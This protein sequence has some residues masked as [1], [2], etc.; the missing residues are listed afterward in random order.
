MMERMSEP[1]VHIAGREDGEE[2]LVSGRYLPP[3]LEEEGFV[4]CSFVGQVVPVADAFFS[5]R[6]DLVLLVI[7]PE[8]LSAELR[9]EGAVPPTGGDEL[10]PHVYGPIEVDAVTDVLDFPCGPDGRFALPARLRD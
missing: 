4:H 9:V 1:V 5:G 3:G 8:R 10:F 6:S 7:D 2:A